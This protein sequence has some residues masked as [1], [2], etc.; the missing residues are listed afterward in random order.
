MHKHTN[1]PS[2]VDAIITKNGK[3]LLIKRGHD[4][5]KGQFALPGGFVDYEERVEQA[6]IREVKEELNLDAIPIAILGVYS[7]PDRDPRGPVISTVFICEFSGT[8]Q[9]GDD[10]AAFEWLEL[11]KLDQI[12]LAFDHNTI[13]DH[14]IR[15][16]IER[17]TYWSTKSL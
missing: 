5:F 11:D 12:S 10:A 6:L 14:Y 1:N 17:G 2:T 16:K 9:A 8:P 7:G 13:L 4:P 3:I 15:W